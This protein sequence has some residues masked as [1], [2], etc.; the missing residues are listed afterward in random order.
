MRSALKVKR[1]YQIGSGFVD[2]FVV[3]EPSNR[4]L[5]VAKSESQSSADTTYV[6]DTFSPIP[7]RARAQRCRFDVAITTADGDARTLSFS[8]ASVR[9]KDQWLQAFSDS[10]AQEVEW[11]ERSG[12]RSGSPG[13]SGSWWRCKRHGLAG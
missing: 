2:C 4:L 13:G 9:L 7:D 8:A 10:S 12:S 5:Q 1:N 6:V 3:F 11:R